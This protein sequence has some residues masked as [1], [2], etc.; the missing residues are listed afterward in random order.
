VAV[1]FA[2]ADRTGAPG[3]PVVAMPPV[4]PAE[5]FSPTVRAA[6]RR[7]RDE[8]RT[9]F[10]SAWWFPL[11]VLLIAMSGSWG[12][13]KA[14]QVI[15]EELIWPAAGV[16][17]AEV[18]PIADDRAVTGR[19]MMIV[20]GG[21]NRKS[22]T[23]PATALLPELAAN[24]SRVYSLVYGSG[25]N[26]QDILDKFDA[27]M[28]EFAPREVSFFGS[29][30]GGDVVLN[31]AAHAQ[32]RRDNYR[33]QL[34]DAAAPFGPGLPFPGSTE[35][36]NARTNAAHIGA[37]LAA[38]PAGEAGDAA[39]AGPAA[40][41]NT[42]ALPAAEAGPAAQFAVG[43]IFA[44]LTDPS[45]AEAATPQDGHSGDQDQPDEDPALPP[46][47]PT[48]GTIYLDCS[49]L[50]ANDVRNSSRTSADALTALTEALHTDGGVLTRLTAEVL[51][52][53]EQWSTG[54]FPFVDI[55]RSDLFYKINQVWRDKI[56]NTGISTQLV[57]DQY[58]VI[59]RMQIDEV[60]SALGTRTRLVYFLPE[61]REHD[62][63]VRVG[64][65]EERLGQ[66]SA[67]NRLDLEVV[68]IAG[69]HHASAESN[70]ELYLAAMADMNR[71]AA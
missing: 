6:L 5:Y 31:L 66:L 4:N 8:R 32:T 48:V 50:D 15:A 1:G 53:Q 35:A 25:I 42:P 27:L 3:E 40:P 49:P 62:R 21:L 45:S 43:A 12:L 41:S 22:G 57:K 68:A 47:P 39:L 52:Q 16:Q 23:G 20:V 71:P 14:D 61:N 9:R 37:A 46:P 11:V 13:L 64:H 58:G 28:A 17:F 65:V 10:R 18:G 33:E 55:R 60:M 44:D 38:G 24:G 56:G 36:H 54:R 67:D 51:A 2:A 26:D 19:P 30:M 69:A 70:S 29:S 7:E 63:T 34:L 59:R